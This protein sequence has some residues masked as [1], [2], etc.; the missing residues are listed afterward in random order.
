M[1]QG[2]SQKE[3]EAPYGQVALKFSMALLN[4]QFEKAYSYLGFSI[5]DKWTPS[6][7]QETYGEMVNYFKP[8]T[9]S[10]DVIDITLPY[11][12]TDSAWIYVSIIGEGDGEA[13]TVI[14]RNENGRYLIQNLEWGRP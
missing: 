1:E 6:I 7:L 3:L 14:V 13:V 5:R 10:V 8:Y 9:V 11:R 12:E 4:G 2:V